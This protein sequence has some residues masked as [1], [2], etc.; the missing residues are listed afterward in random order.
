MRMLFKSFT[1][2]EVIK[3]PHPSQSP[4]DNPSAKERELEDKREDHFLLHKKLFDLKVMN[5]N[6]KVEM[7]NYK[8]LN[9]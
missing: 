4:V 7:L 9:K 1:R 5:R 6:K 3:R 8:C 2:D